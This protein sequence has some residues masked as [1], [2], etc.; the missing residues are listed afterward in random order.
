VHHHHH[1]HNHNR[2]NGLHFHDAT[3]GKGEVFHSEVRWMNAGVCKITDGQ[4]NPQYV[5]HK[6]EVWTKRTY[7]EGDPL[8]AS[9][10]A[11]APQQQAH[12][13]LGERPET[14]GA[15]PKMKKQVY[16]SLLDVVDEI[17]KQHLGQLLDGRAWPP[18][19]SEKLKA[20]LATNN[21]EKKRRRKF[22]G[23]KTVV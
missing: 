21:A 19:D 20:A 2:Q 6:G 18:P 12:G 22:K 23:G 7:S 17:R 16:T 5:E 8:A 4:G 9:P 14:A 10:D 3:S 1:E 13:H 15:G 11:Q